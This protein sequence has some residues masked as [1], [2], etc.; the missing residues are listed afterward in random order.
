MFVLSSSVFN[1]GI[2]NN[3]S[4]L[5]TYGEICLNPENSYSCPCR[6]LLGAELRF[7]QIH[8]LKS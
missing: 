7:P 1:K 6:A 8:M 5:Q 2:N 3:C 4:F